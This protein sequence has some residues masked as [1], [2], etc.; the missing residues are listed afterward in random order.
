MPCASVSPT[1]DLLPSGRDGDTQDSLAYGTV[2]QGTALHEVPG[3]VAMVAVV[4]MAISEARAMC[5]PDIHKQG[6]SSNEPIYQ[7][8]PEIP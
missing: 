7:L 2:F 3:A 5:C 6:I 8:F 1:P 4:T